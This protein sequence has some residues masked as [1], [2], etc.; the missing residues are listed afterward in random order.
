MAEEFL[1]RPDDPRSQVTLI[2]LEA[3]ARTTLVPRQ[4][5]WE[6]SYVAARLLPDG[7][8]VALHQVG[9][10][11]RLVRWT[12]SA[13]EPAWTV[14]VATDRTVGLAALGGSVFV[15]EPSFD[16]SRG[17]A[18]ELTVTPYDAGTG[19]PATG[20]DVIEVR[21]PSGSID[22][23]LFCGEWFGPT[24]LSCAHSG[25]APVLVSLDD[26]SFVELPGQPGAIPTLVRG[27]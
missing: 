16:R 23:G 8:I 1:D 6:S 4:P 24:E 9:V 25:G 27:G 7:D 10:S 5:A 15:M 13:R 11:T 17:F 3:G 21:D 20:E 14:E 22:T 18:P 2:D 26:G 19:E 12:A